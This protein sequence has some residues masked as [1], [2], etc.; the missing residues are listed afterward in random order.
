MAF[1]SRIGA[2]AAAIGLFAA[3]ALGAFAFSNGF[4]ATLLVACL[5]AAWLSAQVSRVVVPAR[6]AAAGSSDVAEGERMMLRAL[7]DQ[8]PGALVSLEGGRAR[9]LN[10]AARVLFV[11]DDVILPPPP[12][13]LVPECRRIRH[14][15]RDWRVDRVEVRGFG[16]PRVILG[17]VDIEAVEH[18]AEARAARELIRVLGH[19]VMNALAPITSLAESALGILEEPD[20]RN[21]LLPEILATLARRTDGL[22]RFTDAYQSVGRLPEPALAPVRIVDLFSELKQLFD[23]EW[24]DRACLEL[25]DPG[26]A[27]V[28]VDR[29]Q[30]VQAILAMLRNGAEAAL[31]IDRSPVV[32]LSTSATDF[33]QTFSISDNGP[34]IDPAQRASIFLLFYTTKAYGNGIGLA[35]ARYIA[36]GH[37]GD[38]KLI[39]GQPTTFEV[40]VRR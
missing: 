22:R 13:L 31:A 25:G 10:R 16:P 28:S 32:H 33:S 12:G 2:T 26:E 1:D 27:V 7:L 6:D 29:D 34:G 35:A 17:L 4:H 37:G 24:R 23:V 30:I 9:A 8:A 14:D 3:G 11:T 20:K 39:P 18:A 5:I 40:S 38:A 19:E 15:H 21:L 36:Q